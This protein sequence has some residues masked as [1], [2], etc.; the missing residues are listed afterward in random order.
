MG[1]HFDGFHCS[2]STNGKKT[3]IDLVVVDIV[4]KSAHFIPVRTRYQ[5]PDIARV[6]ISEIVGCMACLRGLSLIEDQCLLDDC[7][8]VSKRHIT[9]S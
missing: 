5:A 9:R 6:F 8:L 1:S 7:G 2:I 4:M 3:R